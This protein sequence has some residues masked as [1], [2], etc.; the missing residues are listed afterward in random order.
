MQKLNIYYV[1]LTF[2]VNMHG[3]LL[4]KTKKVTTINTFKKILDEFEGHKES[5]IRIDKDSEFYNWS[6]KAWFPKKYIIIYST[7]EGKSVV[8]KRFI[9]T[10]K[11]KI[12]KYMTST[13]KNV[14]INKLDD[15]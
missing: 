2:L 14:Y 8:A 12:Y 1:L 4:W 10:F 11:K 6:V 15:S 9:R 3:L 7:Y 5:K 13:S